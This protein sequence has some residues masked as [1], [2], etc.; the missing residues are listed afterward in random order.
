MAWTLGH[1]RRP[2]RPLAPPRSFAD[3]RTRVELRF[4]YGVAG[5]GITGWIAE[6]VAAPSSVA[7]CAARCSS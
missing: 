5:S 3:G 6:L 2:A 1:R 7:T 4:A